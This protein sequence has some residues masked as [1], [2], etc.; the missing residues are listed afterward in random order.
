MTKRRRLFRFSLATMFLVIAALCIW[1]GVYA[2]WKSQRAQVIRWLDQVTPEDAELPLYYVADDIHYY[3]APL[4]LLLLGDRTI[5]IIVIPFD[6]DAS[7]ELASL[8]AREAKRLFP[9][10]SVSVWHSSTA[11]PGGDSSNLWELSTQ[12]IS[13]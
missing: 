8:R 11:P 6:G 13:K 4:P 1:L 9:E 10:A 7:M 3:P 2:N 12:P 5:R